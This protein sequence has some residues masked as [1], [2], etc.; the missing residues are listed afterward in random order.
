MKTVWLIGASSG[1]GFA[2]AKYYAQQPIK[3]YLSARNIE[4]IS[5]QLQNVVADIEYLSFDLEH[6]EQCLEVTRNLMEREPVI[7]LVIFCAGKIAYDEAWKMD[8]TLEKSI[9]AVNYW[10]PV[11]ISRVLMPSLIANQKGHLVYIGSVSG[12]V[13]SPLR[14]TYAASKHALIGYVRSIRAELRQFNIS[15]SLVNPGFVDTGI[16]M[17]A[18]DGKATLR[19][20]PDMRRL[21]GMD[22]MECAQQIITGIDAGKDEWLIG[23]HELAIVPLQ[24]FFPGLIR[25]ILPGFRPQFET[26]EGQSVDLESGKTQYSLKGT[27][28]TKIVFVNGITS[29]FDVWDEVLCYIDES[30]YQVLLYNYYGRGLSQ[31][32]HANNGIDVLDDQLDELL[33]YLGWNPTELHFVAY[34]WG[35]GWLSRWLLARKTIARSISLLGPAYWNTQ[36]ISVLNGIRYSK[37]G[38]IIFALLGRRLLY[39]DYIKHCNTSYVAK[40]FWEKIK[41]YINHE[42]FLKVFMGNISD[43]IDSWPQYLKGLSQKHGTDIMAISGSADKKSFCGEVV[44]FSNA[45][46]IENLVVLDGVNHLAPLENGLLVSKTIIE[47]ISRH[48]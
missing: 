47:F 37:V 3:M 44:E 17:R 21:K 4:C 43:D 30:K 33:Q 39:F 9:F 5:H 22:V 25:K 23:G 48:E 28:P 38:K 11:S 29:S 19:S 41:V 26:H 32:M 16:D 27:G 46:G 34:S 14:S 42:R 35:C 12:I 6:S 1:I 2:L 36:K 20:R 10:G 15:V 13:P 7:D 31:S 24:R 18:Y 45:T 40:M 8:E